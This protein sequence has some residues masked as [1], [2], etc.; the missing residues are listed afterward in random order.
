VERRKRRGQRCGLDGRRR[1]QL[2]HV[3]L[4]AV[5]CMVLGCGTTPGFTRLTPVE[6]K[7]SKKETFFLASSA[8]QTC[9]PKQYAEWRTS[10]HA[11]A[12]HSPVFLAFNDYVLESTGGSLGTFCD[13]CHSPVGI[14]SGESPIEPNEKRSAVAL[15]SVGC[16][17][18]HSQDTNHA[19]ASGLLPVPI[20]GDPEPTIYGPYYG[21]DEPGAPDDAQRLIKTPHESRHSPLFTSA[22]LCAACHDVFSPDGFRIEEAYSEWKNG[23]Y[24]RRGIACEH[25][26][27]GPEPGKPFLRTEFERDYIVDPSIFPNAPKRYRSNHRFTGPDYS[28]LAHFGKADLALDDEAFAALE[29]QL[30]AE[31]ET[32]LRNAAT[33]EVEVPAEIER[34]GTITA[35]VAVT[36]SG[37][38]HNLPTGFAAER[39]LWLEVTAS[40]AAGAQLFVSGNYDQYEDLRD[41]ESKAVQEGTAP[42]D[43]DLFNLEAAFVLTDF[44]GS[45]SNG[46][47]TTNR[48]LGPVPFLTPPTSATFLQGLPFAGRIFKRGIPPLAT[49]TTEYVVRVPPDAKGPVRLSVRLRYR[50][51]PAHLLRD[52]GV[53]ELVPKLR[54]VDVHTFEREVGLAD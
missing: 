40:D 48:L 14:S 2:N 53:P 17:V 20:P 45:Q 28:M 7:P 51:F 1:A 11:Y 15:D 49:K 33:L 36:N 50:N 6:E 27:M 13:R 31:Q 37:A 16:I 22:H 29:K 19:E 3:G 43:R 25:C 46:I 47:S 35:R 52:L 4:V 34:G 24:A 32:L 26:H 41:W 12:Q 18:C 38:G 23:P 8:C 21:S 9:H 10:M 44:R 39:Q 42:L 30:R 54:I 5:A